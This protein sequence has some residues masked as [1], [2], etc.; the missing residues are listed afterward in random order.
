MAVDAHMSDGLIPF[1]PGGHGKFYV[2][3][4]TRSTQ[5]AE[6]TVDAESADDYEARVSIR[7]GNSQ[8]LRIEL[9]VAGKTLSEKLPAEALKW[10]GHS[11]WGR[12]QL[13]GLLA[14]PAGKSTMTLRIVP[15]DGHL[16]FDAEVHAVE[17]VRPSVRVKLSQ[18]A[19][20]MRADPTWFQQAQYGIMV[21][22]TSQSAP[23]RGNPLPYDQAVT[24]FDV[25]AFAN[26]IERTGAGFVVFTTSHAFQYFP[27]PLAS[28]DK[29]LPGRTSQRDLVADLADELGRRGVK[30][31]LYFHL[32]AIND[33]EWVKASNY[34]DADTRKFFTIWKDI[35][36]EAGNRYREKLA[37]W[38][39]DEGSTSYYFR[40]PDW[41]SLAR[42]A[43]AG[44]P[45]RLV[46]FN[47]WELINPTEFH[48]FCTG[49]GC[50]EPSGFCGV[51][52][53]GGDGR[54][55]TGTHSGLQASACLITERDWG[56]FY[57]NTPFPPP[58][59]TSETLTALLQGFVAHK[60]VPIFNLEI[61]QDG[62][63]SRDTV[64]IF[65]EAKKNLMKR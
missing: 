4:W 14:L 43:K 2:E 46:S 13:A 32:G 7:R 27:A 17:L 59:W 37:G 61:T 30:L 6:W 65:E 21:H 52:K 58:K 29:V 9:N 35:I 3:G 36:S 38:W 26:Q 15:E 48:D 44:H 54:Y 33:P 18:R 24:A 57:S 39:F 8:P 64:A 5:R 23:L 63:L 16:D 25:K 53:R 20:S 19:L 50:Q 62:V 34:F 55:P 42:A 28:L 10:N 12:V 51:L 1:Q 60:N 41:E 45:Q 47:A 56:H 49:E 22:W 31:I 40:S 11:W